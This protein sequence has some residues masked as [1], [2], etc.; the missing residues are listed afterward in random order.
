[1]LDVS[2]ELRSPITRMKVALEFMPEGQA[3]D[4]LKSD[5]AQME[6]IITEILETARM[7]HLH[8]KPHET[9]ERTAEPKNIE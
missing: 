4:S 2:H 7:H 1:M 5:I 3:K 6:T 8:V 9:K